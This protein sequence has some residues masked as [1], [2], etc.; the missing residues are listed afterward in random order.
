MLIGH[1]D[2]NVSFPGACAVQF[3]VFLHHDDLPF[4]FNLLH[5]FLDLVE[6]AAVVLLGYTHKLDKTEGCSLRTNIYFTHSLMLF[7]L[8]L[9]Y[10]LL[11]PTHQ[12]LKLNNSQIITA[13]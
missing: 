7:L 9:C 2:D 10:D 12:K 1:L 5:V 3:S 11:V 13:D 6:D 8:L 4:L